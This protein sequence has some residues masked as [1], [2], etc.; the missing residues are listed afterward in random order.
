MWHNHQEQKICKNPSSRKFYGFVNTKLK[1]KNGI[2]TI[3][4]DDNKD[5]E[6]DVEKADMFN[7]YFQKVFIQDDG[8]DLQI[9]PKNCNIMPSFEIFMSDISFAVENSKDKISRT[10]ESVPT[11]FY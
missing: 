7:L 8:I 5:I 4:N 6:S 2:T 1:S 3:V 11:L 9:Q 10:P